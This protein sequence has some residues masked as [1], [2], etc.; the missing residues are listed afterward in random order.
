MQWQA[1]TRMTTMTAP[2]I[3]FLSFLMGIPVL[4]AQAQ[5][6]LLPEMSF[7]RLLNDLQVTVADTTHVGDPMTIGLV[8]RYGAAFDPADKGGLSHL[9]TRLFGKGTLDRTAKDIQDEIG[10]LGISLDIRTDWDGMRFTLQCPSA[11]YERALLLLYQIVGEAVFNDEDV[12]RVKAEL[13][14]ELDRQ[15]DPRERIRRQFD[16]GLF[17]GTTYGRPIRGTKATLSAITGG[18]VRLHYRRFFCPNLSSLVVAASAPAKDVLQKA[19]RIWGVWVRRDEIPF[20]FV[21]PRKPG[22]R[23]V[24]LEDDPGSPAAQ[25]VLGNLWPRRDDPSYGAAALATRILQERMTRALPTSLVTVASEGRRMPGPFFLQGQA[26][27]D[28]VVDQIG[29]ILALFESLRNQAPTADELNAVRSRWVEEFNRQTRSSGG[30]CSLLLDTDLYRLGTN[31]AA[32]FPD[33]LSRVTPDDVRLAAREWLVPGG[34][35]I[36]LRGPAAQ[37]RPTLESAYG[38]VQSI[39][40]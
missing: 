35:V 15:E 9:V 30:I 7:R 5:P 27:A 2:R 24:F 17:K 11:H 31:Y 16:E 36:L 34:V 20:T 4:A 25:F 28:Q 18:D 26:A 39:A 22:G 33:T 38:T 10:L 21:Q 6:V 19:A 8:V 29:K 3:L 12:N 37:L 1:F 13:L 40:P 14:K 32:A 23:N